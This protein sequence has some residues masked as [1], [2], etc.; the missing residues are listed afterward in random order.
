MGKSKNFIIGEKE[1]MK[2]IENGKIK[3]I[4]FA[5]NCPEFIRTKFEKI[6]IEK[7]NFSGNEEELGAYIGKAFPIAIVGVKN[8]NNS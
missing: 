4:I 6:D 7:E 5:S 3:K 1:I 2:G 8:E